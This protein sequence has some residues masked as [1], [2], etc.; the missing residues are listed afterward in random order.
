MKE[1]SNNISFR[2][3]S[4]VSALLEEKAKERGQSP[5]TYARQLVLDSLNDKNTEELRHDLDELRDQVTKLREDLATAVV[6][7]LVNDE[8]KDEEQAKAWVRNTLMR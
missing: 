6:A 7:L 8:P 5:G 2:I 3:P 1:R 4:T